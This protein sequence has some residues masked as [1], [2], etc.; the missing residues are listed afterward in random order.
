L[1]NAN[2][3]VTKIT[4]KFAGTLIDGVLDFTAIQ[5]S[6]KSFLAQVVVNNHKKGVFFEIEGDKIKSTTA[7]DC[8]LTDCQQHLIDSYKTIASSRTVGEYGIFGLTLSTTH[9]DANQHC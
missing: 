7:R 3:I 6:D 1:I 9:L 8:P 4:G 2:N 5:L